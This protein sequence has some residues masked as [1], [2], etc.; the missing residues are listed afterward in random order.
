MA[1]IVLFLVSTGSRNG[2]AGHFTPPKCCF[3]INSV[4][5][6]KVGDRLI[7]GEF[8]NRDF[9]IRKFGVIS[10]DDCGNF[11]VKPVKPLFHFASQHIMHGE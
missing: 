8:E 7:R 3:K 11:E 4:I 2:P 6:A 5:L 9:S 10:E 1:F